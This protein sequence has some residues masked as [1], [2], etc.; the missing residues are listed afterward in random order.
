MGSRALRP[1]KA[2]PPP[3]AAPKLQQTLT[4]TLK[5]LSEKVGFNLRAQGVLDSRAQVLDKA[6]DTYCAV[7]VSEADSAVGSKGRKRG[8]KR[9]GVPASLVA[10]VKERIQ[11]HGEVLMRFA[12]EKVRL[13]QQS[14]D[15][16][17][18]KIRVIDKDLSRIEADLARREL[19]PSPNEAVVDKDPIASEPLYCLCN[20]VAFGDMV[21][22]D[23]PQCEREWFHLKCVHLSKLPT[24][25]V[26]VRLSLART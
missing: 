2:A 24:G 17:D 26:W 23:D 14:Y 10:A 25:Q 19:L 8:K 12:D 6:L 7:L 1:A 4:S 5:G 22:C 18:T 13:A 21:G 9:K 15:M 20:Q 11:S 16:L 3:K